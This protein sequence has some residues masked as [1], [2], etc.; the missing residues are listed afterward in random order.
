MGASSLAQGDFRGGE[1]SPLAQGRWDDPRYGTA[2]ALC[3]NAIPLEEGA[4]PRR[5]GFQH[6]GVTRHG[7]P[8]RVYKFTVAAA[9]PYVM[10]FTDGFMRLWLNGQLVTTNDSLFCTCSGNVFTVTGGTISSWNG[11]DGVYINQAGFASAV[12]CQALS[13]R[14][15]TINKLSPTTFTLTDPLTG[16]VLQSSDIGT[17]SLF[18]GTINHILELPTPW[19]NGAWAN[20]FPVQSELQM[21]L[22]CPGVAPQ[23]LAYSAPPAGQTYG[24]FTLAPTLFI[25][26]PYND[27]YTTPQVNNPDPSLSPPPQAQGIITGGGP[28]YTLT[29]IAGNPN[30]GPV[31]F[32]STDVGRL[33][34]M[35]QAPPIWSPTTVYFPGQLVSYKNVPYVVIRGTAFSEVIPD[36]VGGAGFW[37]VSPESQQY[38]WGVI[39][40]VTTTAQVQVTINLN[41][42]GSQF[43]FNTEGGTTNNLP[44]M[45]VTGIQ[46]GTYTATGNV[47]PT[48]GCYHEG[49]LFLAGAVANRFDASVSN[50][51]S[52]PATGIDFSP[53]DAAGTVLDSSAITETLNAEEV[54]PIFWLQPSLQ[55]VV[56][57]TQEGEWLIQASANNNILTDTS[58]QAHMVTKYGCA[59]VRPVRT[60]ISTAFVQ[61]YQRRLHEYLSDVFSGRFFGPNLSEKTKHLT[62]AGIEE[63]AYQEELAPIV[64]MRMGDGTLKGT[65]YRRTSLF[66]SQ[67]P[68]CNAWHQHTLGSGET[69][70]SITT[71]PTSNGDLDAL[72]VT[73][74]TPGQVNGVLGGPVYRV[75]AL[76]QIF[77]EDTPLVNSWHVDSG[78]VPSAM[79]SSSTGVTLYGLWHLNGSKCSVVIA[80][81][82]CGDYTISGGSVFVPWS[83]NPN[84][85]LAELNNIAATTPVSQ[86]A[87]STIMDSDLPVPAVV[88]FTYTTQCQQ[89]RSALRGPGESGAVQGHA[90][91]K[92]RR[93]HRYA[94]LLN[95]AI[96]STIQ[97]GTD[98][99]RTLSPALLKLANLTQIDNTQLYSGVKTDNLDGDYEYDNGVAWQIT[100]PVPG[101]MVALQGFLHTQDR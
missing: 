83:A 56:M 74:Y 93:V 26:G 59:N 4:L 61:R 89:L 55:G 29:L 37:Q 40:A 48:C 51:A 30:I 52:T 22:L 98:L 85:S 1:W 18:S 36:S 69:I 15:F 24:A 44:P 46:L 71:G 43:F 95:N 87:F 78:V 58:I 99:L 73:T 14:Q 70:T 20:V 5:P 17:P 12:A 41:T 76:T 94:A 86:F 49:R 97:F 50:G 9:S 54:N 53:T 79:Q 2:L 65:T 8:G 88:G 27:V 11:G 31:G 96:N 81:L 35:Q 39:N 75:Q 38:L 68:E 60:G 6:L 33:I 13:D 63:L 101:T 91:G 25:N 19:T 23:T 84:L 10:E 42:N 62:V 66:S 16:N 64:W 77:D 72:Y 21:T 45:Q 47:Y 28:S 32:Q 90:L 34:R 7:K 92:T 67:P 57:G 80:G 100:R 82:D 3:L